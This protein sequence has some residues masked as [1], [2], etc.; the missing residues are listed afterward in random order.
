MASYVFGPVPSRR[1]GRSLGIDV[2]PYKTCTYDC[3]YCQL[4]RTT[5]K[6]MARS[7]WVPLNEVVDEIQEK[8][9]LQPNYITL[10][11]SGEPTLYN[12]TGELIDRIRTL[13]KIPV[14]VLTNGSLLWK[15]DVRKEL[16]A[17][18]VV[19]PS[20][21]AGDQRLFEAVNRPHG[22]IAF[23]EMMEGLILFREK[24]TGDYWLE[25]FLL[26]GHTGMPAE[27]Q[28]LVQWTNRIKPARVHLNTVCRPPAEEY[29]A[30][31]NRDRMREFAASF[32]P[33]AEIIAEFPD[34]HELPEFKSSRREVLHL[35]QR[36]PCTVHDLAIGLGMHDNEV[37]KHLEELTAQGLLTW[38]WVEGERFY[39]CYRK[40]GS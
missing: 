5:N 40:T 38:S 26:A 4:G 23:E 11:G 32:N 31:V 35:L 21:D 18:Q 12:R 20:L 34:I 9:S 13:T 3:I 27:V 39:R 6:T 7:E 22:G 10:S 33:A 28:K 15:A 8:L 16:A 2:V 29:A 25:I 19:I 24:Y 37:T 1:L 36:R 14:A 17:A 30:A